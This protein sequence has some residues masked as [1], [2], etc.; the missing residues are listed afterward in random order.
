MIKWLKLL[1]EESPG[2]NLIYYINISVLRY[3]IL[4]FVYIVVV[5]RMSYF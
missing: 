1:D 3:A 4:T 2:Y 5:G